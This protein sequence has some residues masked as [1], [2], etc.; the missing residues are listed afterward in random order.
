MTKK[1]ATEKV[2]EISELS[3]GIGGTEILTKIALYYGHERFWTRIGFGK[4]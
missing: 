2:L 1:M 4:S 3:V